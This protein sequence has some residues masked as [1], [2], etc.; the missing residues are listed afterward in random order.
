MTA[1]KL[2]R[3]LVGLLLV[4]LGLAALRD[5]ARLGDALPWRTMD[6]FPDF[7][8]AGST[9]DRG[10]GPYT[11]EPLRTC[12]HR[13]NAG[14]AFRGRLFASL[15][16]IAIPAPQPPYDFPPF[17]AIA[18]L[19]FPAARAIDAVAIVLAVVA[20]VVAMTALGVPLPLAAAV[21]ALSTAYASL[22]TGQIVPFALLAL[23]LCGLALQRR[24]DGLAG[25][26][27][28]L[29]AIEPTLGVAAVAATL[30]FVPRA[31]L[32]ALVTILCLALAATAVA[33]RSG[34]ATYLTR[35]LP[36]H[37]ASELHFPFQYSLT[38]LL[39]YFGMPGVPA[40]LL[41]ALSYVAFVAAALW[42]A[43]R[44]SEALAQ[45]ALLVFIPALG[46]VIGGAFVH[47]EELAFALPALTILA[48]ETAGWARVASAAALCILSLPWIAIWGAKQ[49]FLASLFVCA[50]IL[51]SL[52]LRA[53]EAW[54][55]FLGIA[56]ALYGFELFPPSLPVPAAGALHAYAP[57]ELVQAAWRDYTEARSTH[58][59]G[60]VAIKLPAWIALLAA[61]WVALRSQAPSISRRI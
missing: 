57:N 34:V 49:L 48:L 50:V 43:P 4:A 28:V 23:L 30:L 8:C 18:R 54:P 12:E 29:T 61:L 36:A 6:D 19:P 42:I 60:W 41:G 10:A 47:Q 40:Q 15:P 20:C 31:R 44:T 56:A 14:P 16:A 37:A 17:M 9:L 59:F 26:L 25:V 45:R 32:A 52:R 35:V 13:V 2:R 22:R 24:R 38:Y 5:F 1:A 51:L 58:D 55:I 27:A 7:Y 33:G 53:R 11:Y 3:V 39:G 21:F 46:C